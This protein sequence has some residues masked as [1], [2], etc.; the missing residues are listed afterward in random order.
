MKFETLVTRYKNLGYE[1]KGLDRD[2]EVFSISK[3][4]GTYQ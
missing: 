4:F 3:P 2:Y 1:P